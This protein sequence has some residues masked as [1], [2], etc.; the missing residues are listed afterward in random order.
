MQTLALQRPR[1]GRNVNLDI[2]RV[3]GWRLFCN[4][5]GASVGR[6][7]FSRVPQTPGT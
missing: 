1:Q 2:N 7:E 6:V 3:V 5:A 4:K